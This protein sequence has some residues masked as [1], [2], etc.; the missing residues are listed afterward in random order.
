MIRINNSQLA[1]GS[2]NCIQNIDVNTEEKLVFLSDTSLK[3][4]KVNKFIVV[5]LIENEIR[6][7]FWDIITKKIILSIPI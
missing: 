4:F 6:W 5:S 1:I 3:L 2:K 7:N